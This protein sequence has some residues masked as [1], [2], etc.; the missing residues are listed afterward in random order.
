MTGRVYI[1]GAI[2]GTVGYLERFSKAEEKMKALGYHVINPA[3]IMAEFPTEAMSYEDYVDV[4]LCLLKMCDGIYMIPGW[5]NSKGARLENTYA[6]S[7]DMVVIEEGDGGE[8]A[9]S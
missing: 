9:Y 4:S 8:L 7:V 6:K 5:E 2:T 1:S 3:R